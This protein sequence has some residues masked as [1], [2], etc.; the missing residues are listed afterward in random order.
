MK[1]IGITGGVGTGKSELLSYIREHYNCHIILADEAAHEI[2]KPGGKGY[3]ELVK[4]L[5]DDILDTD[6][7]IHKARMAEK[8]FG[9]TELLNRV[10]Q[11]IHPKVKEYILQE[12]AEK[13]NAGKIDFLFV[14]AALL[15]EDGYDKILDELWY[16][17]T[18]TD[19]RKE[20]LRTSRAYSDEKIER[21][22]QKQLSEEEFRKHCKVV[23]ENNESLGAAYKQIDEKLEEYLCQ[24]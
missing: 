15:I 18:R 3:D 7:T 13:K 22:L 5:G 19:I 20:R 8:I 21:I 14:E 24:R 12:I 1:T 4:L 9:D 17:H 16:I 10:N 6:G 11:I 23:I 2:E